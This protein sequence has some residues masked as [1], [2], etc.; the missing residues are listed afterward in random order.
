MELKIRSHQIRGMQRKIAGI[1]SDIGDSHGIE[2]K[3]H[4]DTFLEAILED[5]NIN[6]EI[7]SE[8]SSICDPKC[9]MNYHR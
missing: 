3:T 7:T 6:I 4:E 9:K 5:P 2:V 1:E 8:N